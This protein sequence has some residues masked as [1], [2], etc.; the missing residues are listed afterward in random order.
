MSTRAAY[1]A[2]VER[3]F[4]LSDFTFH[5]GESLPQLKVRY[6]TV[7]D[8]SGVPALILHGTARSGAAMLAPAFADELFG[9]GRP[10]D[11]AKYYL[12]LPDAV[13]AGD[14]AKPSDGLRAKFPRYNYAD[15][16][17]AQYRLLTEALGVA[18]LRVIVGNSMGGMHAWLWA[19]TYPGFMDG[20]VPLAAQP[21][22]MSG[23]NWMLRRLLT[24][25]VR[26]DPA[27]MG[28]EYT[29]QPERFRLMHVWYTVATTGGDL[30]YL[31]KAPNREAADALLA[32]ML[33]QQTS[34][35]AND[36]L[37]QWDASRDYDPLPLLDKVKAR[38]LAV[39]SADDERNPHESGLMNRALERLQNAEYHL[40][41]AAENTSGHATTMTASF[42]KARLERFMQTLPAGG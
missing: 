25:S 28:G 11:A 39:N 36:F 2:P 10:L 19:G 40:I 20:I 15:M 12:I 17:L 9:P 18:H 30:A 14:S 6:R 35:D 41:P 27:W 38:V 7:G 31:A 8:P 37:Y 23:R 26:Q 34:M 24:D 16:V 1:P 3:D 21:A 13:G 5:T 22:P 42:W 4:V 29:E 33:A 32:R